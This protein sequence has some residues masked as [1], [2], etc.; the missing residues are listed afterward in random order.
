[1]RAR[2]CHAINQKIPMAEAIYSARERCDYLHKPRHELIVSDVLSWL[3]AKGIISEK[4]LN[5][6]KITQVPPFKSIKEVIHK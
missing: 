3:S 6:L 5:L 4:M 1:M 2:I